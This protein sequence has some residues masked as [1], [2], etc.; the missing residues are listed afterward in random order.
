M[1]RQKSKARIFQAICT[2]L[3][4]WALFVLFLHAWVRFHPN[5]QPQ[6]L[7]PGISSGLVVT[8]STKIPVT[9][10]NTES[11]RELGLSGTTV[12]PVHSGKLF[13][14]ETPDKYSFW[15]KD[16]NYPIDIVWI[17]QNLKIVDISS[18]ISPST[19]PKSFEA[20]TPVLYVLEINALESSSDGLFVGDKIQLPKDF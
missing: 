18:N 1:L 2:L 3:A 19:Y 11:L 12:L 15:M 9:I 13:I 20:S 14:F 6:G 17:D 5:R 4:G 10:A 7:N 16:M 8:K